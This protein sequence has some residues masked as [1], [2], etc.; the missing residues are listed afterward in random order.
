MSDAVEIFAIPAYK[1]LAQYDFRH[2]LRYMGD[3][4]AT[5]TTFAVSRHRDLK[6][7]R[8][9]SSPFKGVLWYH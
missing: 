8:R 7:I 6:V 4:P 9:V 5:F 3:E 1:G 2:P